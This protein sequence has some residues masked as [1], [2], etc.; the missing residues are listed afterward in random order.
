M[1]FLRKFWAVFPD[2][3]F[4]PDV[5]W[6]WRKFLTFSCWGHSECSEK[7]DTEQ[8]KQ[9]KYTAD[10]PNALRRVPSLTRKFA[11]LRV[12]DWR[13][14]NRYTHFTILADKDTHSHSATEVVS[15]SVTEPSDLLYQMSGW[16]A[17][18][19]HVIYM[20]HHVAVLS[21]SST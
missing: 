14:E 5:Y 21:K 11:T 6:F 4:L 1:Q 9:N 7:Q 15:K 17:T 20:A 3:F 16:T 10:R 8:K 12:I 18:V 13:M 2:K 19:C